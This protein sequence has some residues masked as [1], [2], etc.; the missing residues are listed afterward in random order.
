MTV[1]AWLPNIQQG[2]LFRTRLRAWHRD[3]V[4]DFPWRRRFGDP[5]AVLIAELL[6][7]KTTAR[8]VAGVYTDFL[9]E[10]PSPGSLAEAS[11]DGLS[12]RLRPLGLAHRADLLHRLGASLVSRHG[13]RV[14]NTAGELMK[15]P[16]VGRYTANAVL[17]FAYGQRVPI[18][19]SNVIRVLKRVFGVVSNRSRAHLDAQMWQAASALLPRLASEDYQLALLDFAAIVCRHRR[20]QC[21]TCPIRPGCAFARSRPTLTA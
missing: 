3:N 7:R 12:E 1:A 16:G 15:L 10:Y 14:P 8:Q 5:Y 18:V 20:P 9:S 17:C 19:D 13:G 11:I 4:R 6:L 2:K 21:A